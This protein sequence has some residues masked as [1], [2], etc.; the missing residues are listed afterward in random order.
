MGLPG[1]RSYQDRLKCRLCQEGVLLG[2]VLFH[3]VSSWWHCLLCRHFLPLPSGPEALL[4]LLCPPQMTATSGCNCWTVLLHLYSPHGA[5][6]CKHCP[7]TSKPMV[8][9]C[10]L[11]SHTHLQLAVQQANLHLPESFTRSHGSLP[12]LLTPYSHSPYLGQ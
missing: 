9:K 3:P 11:D 12:L 10:V 6:G 7:H 1:N 5:P 8:T 2:L 4:I